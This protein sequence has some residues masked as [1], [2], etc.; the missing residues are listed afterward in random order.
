MAQVNRYSRPAQV[1]KFNPLT[2]QDIMAIPLLKQE[3]EDQQIAENREILKELYNTQAV[4]ADQARVNAARADL[5]GQLLAISDDI[6]SNGV[7]RARTKQF[8]RLK[9]AFDKELSASGT[10]GHANAF[11]EKRD[12]AKGNFYKWATEAGWDKDKMD[13]YWSKHSQTQSAFNEDGTFNTEYAELGLP[14]YTDPVA[15]LYSRAKALGFKKMKGEDGKYYT[16]NEDQVSSAANAIL[17]E[18]QDPN[19]GVGRLAEL[20]GWSQDGVL[21]EDIIQKIESTARSMISYEE[22]DSFNEQKELVDLK[23]AAAAQKKVLEDAAKQEKIEGQTVWSISPS[24]LRESGIGESAA[25]TQEAMQDLIEEIKD[26]EP[27]DRDA[28]EDKLNGM[29][30]VLNTMSSEYLTTTQGQNAQAALRD[31]YETSPFFQQAEKLGLDPYYMEESR[32]GS[33]SFRDGNTTHRLLPSRVEAY[34]KA[35]ETFDN[36]LYNWVGKDSS[37]FEEKEYVYAGASGNKTVDDNMKQINSGLFNL[38]IN[39]SEIDYKRINIVKENG[40]LEEWDLTEKGG[41]K[42]DVNKDR[43][44][45]I[46]STL[47]DK[48]LR[49]LAQVP[50][51]AVHN[52]GFRV[53]VTIPKERWNEPEFK[54]GPRFFDVLVEVNPSGDGTAGMTLMT[55]TLGKVTRDGAA[56]ARQNANHYKYSGFTPTYGDRNGYYNDDDIKAQMPAGGRVSPFLQE[57]DKIDLYFDDVTG[58]GT[59]K[60]RVKKQTEEGITED[61]EYKDILY[62]V[63]DNTADLTKL[64]ISKP[65][66][67]DLIV[68]QFQDELVGMTEIEAGK[69]F[70]NKIKQLKNSDEAILSSNAEQLL[71]LLSDK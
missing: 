44:S 11:V 53:R 17:R 12:L 10:L 32:D 62:D 48:D 47:N 24:L 58:F 1:A 37:H 67:K 3:M 36:G 8:Q 42:A 35:R 33:L 61:L 20:E 13:R 29:R 55:D 52:P 30:K 21:V 45:N 22:D 71:E 28:L 6:A 49:V 31:I 63:P 4:G 66:L 60:F 46:I 16:S 56:L 70:L 7:S 19:T 59:K 14:K 54:D 64:L 18:M 34:K 5:E 41:R 57:N 26:A 25:E 9:S 65:F 23:N 27:K 39:N 40:D 43:F 15:L 51:N 38:M 69:W 68:D 2:A 50:G